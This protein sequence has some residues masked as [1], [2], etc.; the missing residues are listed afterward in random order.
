LF[1][2]LSLVDSSARWRQSASMSDNKGNKNLPQFHSR[3]KRA[4]HTSRVECS[5]CLLTQLRADVNQC[6]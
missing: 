2:L 6:H 5:V 4:L 3:V 1:I